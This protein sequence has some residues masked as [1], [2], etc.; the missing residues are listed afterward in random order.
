ME[1][2]I[3][4][5]HGKPIIKTRTVQM[6]S[7]HEEIAVHADDG[8]KLYRKNVVYV[9]V[10]YEYCPVC[11]ATLCSRWNIHCGKCGAKMSSGADN[12]V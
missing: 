6:T 2:I 1:T 3:K 7:Y 11:G 12:A 10:P 9:D 8:A 5:R 4:A